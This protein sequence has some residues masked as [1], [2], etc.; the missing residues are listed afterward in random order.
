VPQPTAEVSESTYFVRFLRFTVRTGHASVVRGAIDH[1]S[2]GGDIDHASDPVKRHDLIK[3]VSKR[4]VLDAVGVGVRLHGLRE[5][6]VLQ[7][8]MSVRRVFIQRG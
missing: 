6:P 8:V 4:K 1:E 5:G 7:R 3:P 2:L